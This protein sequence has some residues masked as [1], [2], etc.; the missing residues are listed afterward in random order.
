MKCF[1]M[2]RF[3]GFV[4]VAILIEIMPCSSDPFPFPTKQEKQLWKAA[5]NGDIK[6]VR[7][8]ITSGADVNASQESG[9]TA[10]T[11]A[12]VW[13][14]SINKLGVAKLLLQSGAKVDPIVQLT[15]ATPLFYAAKTGNFALTQL[16][17]KHGAKANARDGDNSV[18]MWVTEGNTLEEAKAVKIIDL[19]IKHGADVNA[20]SSVGNTA[21]SWAKQNSRLK[22]ARFLVQKGAKE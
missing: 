14:E 19:L 15:G 7:Q 22:V 6:K 4:F 16:L 9:Y 2:V 3:V 5:E 12:V 8:L 11:F 21:L 13:S 17:L 20:K 1:K 10:L 18:I